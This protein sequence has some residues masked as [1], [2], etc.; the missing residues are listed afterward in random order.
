MDVM[1]EDMPDDPL[2]RN[3]RS[4]FS[5]KSCPFQ[6]HLGVGLERWLDQFRVTH[7][8]RLIQRWEDR[9]KISSGP[10]GKRL[11]DQLPGLLKSGN[12]FCRRVAWIYVRLTDSQCP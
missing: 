12:Q 2:K 1:F 5:R 9:E 3:F 8:F 7:T 10:A 11:L 4:H 6:P